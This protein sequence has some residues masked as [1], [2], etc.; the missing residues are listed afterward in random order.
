[1]HVSQLRNCQTWGTLAKLWCIDVGCSLKQPVSGLALVQTSNDLMKHLSSFLLCC[2]YSPWEEK[3]TRP[4]RA[5]LLLF[6]SSS[7]TLL[8]CEAFSL[9]L[10]EAEEEEQEVFDRCAGLWNHSSAFVLPQGCERREVWERENNGG[11]RLNLLF[12]SDINTHTPSSEY[13]FCEQSVLSRQRVGRK[14]GR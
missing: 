6:S 10:Q 8:F 3:E 9:Y 12:G 14:E 4:E 11:R 2:L 1:M 13:Y 7:V 5:L